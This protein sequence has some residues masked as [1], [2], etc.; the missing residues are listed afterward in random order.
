MKALSIVIPV[1][2]DA[3]ALD[4]LLAQLQPERGPLTEVIVVD[5][6]SRD[7]LAAV[8]AGRVDRLLAAPPGRARQMNAGAAA[9]RGRALWFLHA[10]SHLPPDAVAQVLQALRLRFWGRFDVRIEGRSRWLPLIAR[11]MNTRSRWTGIAT[12]D[13][14]VFVR[15]QCFHRLGGFADLPLMED[16]EFSRRAR[17]LG[18]PACL[19]ERLVTSGR[20]WDHHGAWRTIALMSWLRLRFWLGA[21][22]RALHALYYP[23]QGKPR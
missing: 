16:V 11:M 2:D 6:G 19:G 14:G 18:R 21:D 20:R 10:D 3:P 4:R 13:Q 12:G 1:L 22:A 5:G 23:S 15:A 9:A 17:S 7:G 8:C